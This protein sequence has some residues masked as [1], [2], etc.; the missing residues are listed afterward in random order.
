MRQLILASQSPWRAELLRQLNL[1]FE[2]FSPSIDETKQPNESIDDYMLRMAT[3]KAAIGYAAYPQHIVIAADTSAE[4]DGQLLGKPQ[5][6]AESAAMLKQLS[7]KTHTILTSFAI[8]DGNKLHNEVVRTS[9]IMRP[10]LPTEIEH[11][12]QTR[13]PTDKAGSYAI[14]GLGAVFVKE[15]KGSYSAVMGLPLFELANALMAYNVKVF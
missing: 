11:Y 2:Q 4:L 14:Q 7:A 12:W 15:I 3:E 6:L 10:I 1:T 13:E 5:N 8:F 9:V